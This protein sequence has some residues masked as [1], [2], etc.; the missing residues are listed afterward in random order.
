MHGKWNGFDVTQNQGDRSK[1]I[2]N[3]AQGCAIQSLNGKRVF[4]NHENAKDTYIHID[5]ERIR[6]IIFYNNRNN[7]NTQGKL[8]SKELKMHSDKQN[9][10]MRRIR[11]K[12]H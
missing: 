9:V 2:K 10:I 7:D 8:S 4:E 5:Y 1:Q 6:L 3:P 11:R 12:T